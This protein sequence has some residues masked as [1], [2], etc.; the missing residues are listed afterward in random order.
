[1]LTTRLMLFSRTALAP[2]VAVWIYQSRKLG[3]SSFGGVSQNKASA[4]FVTSS[5]PIASSLLIDLTV[6]PR[7]AKSDSFSGCL[8]RRMVSTSAR[9]T[10]SAVRR[11]ILPEAAAITIFMFFFPTLLWAICI[12]RLVQILCTTPCLDRRHRIPIFAV[13]NDLTFLSF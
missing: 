5:N 1:M 4:S 10:F 11:P 7:A 12:E 6:A 8:V 13:V 3:A 9:T 2:V